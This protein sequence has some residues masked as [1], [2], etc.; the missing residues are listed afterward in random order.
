MRKHL[1][2]AASSLCRISTLLPVALGPVIPRRRRAEGWPHSVLIPAL[3]I[4]VVLGIA[5]CD[6]RKDTPNS[7]DVAM[8]A[9][10]VSQDTFEQSAPDG[11]QTDT[12]DA[13]ANDTDVTEQAP[14]SMPPDTG[15]DEEPPI[16]AE[17]AYLKASNVGL[18]KAQLHWGNEQ[19]HGTP[20]V[21]DNIG[22]TAYAIYQDGAVIVEMESD[23]EP[24][25]LYVEEL[26]PETV[27]LFQ[28][29]AG[30]AAG[31]WSTDGP[32]VE[33]QTKCATYWEDKCPVSWPPDSVLTSE[34]TGDSSILLTWTPAH[35]DMEVTSY[36]VLQDGE[37]LCQDFGVPE[38]NYT[39][40]GDVTEYEVTG[41][42]LGETYHFQIS[43][44]DSVGIENG[45]GGFI[46]GP[47]VE[48]TL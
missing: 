15:P 21:S 18:Y 40:E 10:P 16:W 30:D 22:V 35:D 17:Y 2:R 47:E 29:Q 1:I 5:G 3:A 7:E 44:R 41:L 19:E 8:D 34:P 43:G 28:I 39:V 23:D 46:L 6:G 9:P 36:R 32:S 13:V 20:W 48:V 33:V 26:Q 37:C 42:Q 12:E 11:V 4:A 38:T 45:G 14:D 31:N 24:V 27:Y 25:H